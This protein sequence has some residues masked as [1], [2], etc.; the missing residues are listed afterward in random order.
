M[1]WD[2]RPNRSAVKVPWSKLFGNSQIW[3]A[4]GDVFLLRLQHRHLPHL[5][6]D[7]SEGSAF[8]FNLTKMGLYASMPLMAGVAGDVA[9]GWISDRMAHRIGQSPVAAARRDVGFLIAAATIPMAVLSAPI[10]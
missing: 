1:R 3:T 10:R 6:P 2:P 4:V 5:V 7:L 8:G 9:G